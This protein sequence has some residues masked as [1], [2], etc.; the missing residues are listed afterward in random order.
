[1]LQWVARK[2]IFAWVDNTQY[3]YAFPVAYGTFLKGLFFL[4][5]DLSGCVAAQILGIGGIDSTN[6]ALN[7]GSSPRICAVVGGAGGT[8]VKLHISGTYNLHT[9]ST[10]HNMV[11][12]VEWGWWW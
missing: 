9:S 10:I 7:I 3:S 2:L 12:I 11:W 4:N 5:S 6:S 1:V 8:G